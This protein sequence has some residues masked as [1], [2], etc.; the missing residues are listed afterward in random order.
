MFSTR[1]Q[2][3]LKKWVLAAVCALPPLCGTAQAAGRA[4][5]TVEAEV[6]GRRVEGLPLSWSNS[7]VFLLARDGYL[8]QFPPADARN[9]RKT[10]TS[11]RSFS[12]GELRSSLEAELG[13]NLEITGT[14]HYLVAHPR[15]KGNAWAGRFE[16]LYRSFVHYFA[17][18]GL[19]VTA[20]QFPLVAIVWSRQEDF[21]RYAAKEGHRAAESGLGPYFSSG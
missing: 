13:Q 19:T 1:A 8:W 18:R 21:L 16:D 11:F 5:W 15:G 14:G 20:P 17:V 2:S 12:A 7:E 6:K 3:Q 9:F 10:S 4:N